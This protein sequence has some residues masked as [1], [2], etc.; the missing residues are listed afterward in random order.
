LDGRSM[1][2]RAHLSGLSLFFREAQPLAC[3]LPAG[4]A[5]NFRGAN[6]A[7]MLRT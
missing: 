5:G 4:S 2:S 1:E 6:F 3:R 7:R